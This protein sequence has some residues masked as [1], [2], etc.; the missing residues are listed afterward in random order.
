MMVQSAVDLDRVEIY[1]YREA[2]RQPIELA[3]GRLD[4]REGFYIRLLDREGR[5][6]YGEVAPLPGYSFET[7]EQCQTQ[8]L[9][10]AE[11]RVSRIP[12][13]PA[14]LD[15]VDPKV[16]W[17][18]S[19]HFGW[20]C[21]AR[22]LLG[23][24]PAKAAIPLNGVVSGTRDRCVR[25]VKHLQQ[26]GI[27]SIKLKVGRESNSVEEEKILAVADCLPEGSLRIDA[28]RQWELAGCVTLASRLQSITFDYWEEPLAQPEQLPLFSEQTGI[29]F[30]YD[31]TIARRDEKNFAAVPGLKA[32]VTK[33]T[34]LGGP[35][36]LQRWLQTARRLGLSLVL[37]STFESPLAH[38]HLAA[39]GELVADEFNPQTP[40]GLGTIEWVGQG[41]T[42]AAW[43][44][45]NGHLQ[46]EKPTIDWNRCRRIR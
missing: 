27:N 1:S 4:H 40:A 26:R 25:E 28:N 5:E 29:P 15:T 44:I 12:S 14:D 10:L 11:G 22:D 8:L 46:L 9:D 18:P 6:G 17:Y 21:A 31:E 24:W 36:R 32:L 43:S 45:D 30:A 19:V 37:S 13:L 2:I 38:Y 20:E 39:W 7:M 23:L 16:R 34:M 41:A 42:H 33:P 3:M 35:T